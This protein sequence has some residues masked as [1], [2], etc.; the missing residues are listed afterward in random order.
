MEWI[1]DQWENNFWVFSAI[2]MIAL[3]IFSAV[4]DRRR[5][6]RKSIED[7]GFMPWS[8]ITVMAVLGALISI[9]FAIKSGV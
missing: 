9:A 2:A 5:Q 4:A 8:A 7:V 1:A 6:H 3:I